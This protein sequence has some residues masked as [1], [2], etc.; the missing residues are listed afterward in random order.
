MNLY[1]GLYFFKKVIN[2]KIQLRGSKHQCRLDGRN[3]ALWEGIYL[4]P[5]WLRDQSWH[6]D[7]GATI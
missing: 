2:L 7:G 6:D 3:M 4:G 5:L 1:G